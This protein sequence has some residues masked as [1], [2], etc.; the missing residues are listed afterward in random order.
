MVYDGILL[1]LIVG[2]IRK[3]NLRGLAQLKLKWGW[4]FP[5]LLIVQI[6]TFVYQNDIKF[7]G[8]ASESIYMVVYII[9]LLFL[10]LNRNHKGFMIIFIGVFLNFLVMVVN[11]GR[12][13]VSEEAAAVLDPMYIQAL[14]DGLYAKHILLTDSTILG[15]LGDIIPLGPPYPRTQVISIG[16]VVMNIGA[17]LFIQYLMLQPNKKNR[18]ITSHSLKGGETR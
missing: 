3:G 4:I 7:L 14:K 5:L 16:D 6:I 13:P 17:F 9:G 11:G 1:S 2:F 12:M 15:F 10:Y 8:K 18:E